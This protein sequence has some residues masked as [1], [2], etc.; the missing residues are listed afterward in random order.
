MGQLNNV[1]RSEKK[2]EKK[3]KLRVKQPPI[4]IRISFRQK[5]SM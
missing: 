5:Y 4:I 3:D 1:S 2:K